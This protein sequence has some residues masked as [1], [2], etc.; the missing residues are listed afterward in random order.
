[1]MPF[2][3]CSGGVSLSADKSTA[4]L[5]EGTGA[6]VGDAVEGEGK[7]RL[8]ITRSRNNDGQAMVL[9]VTTASSLSAGDGTAWGVAP[10][11]GNLVVCES[12]TQFGG[13]GA[14]LG[15]ALRK[16]TANGGTIEIHATEDR[17]LML[18]ATATS[19]ASAWVDACVPPL[20]PSV[21]PWVL[22]MAKGDEVSLQRI[23]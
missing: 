2:A 3:E 9:G 1:M 10:S 11:R 16:G 13:W 17:R 19:Y 15:L 8:I 4:T 23:A 18:R 22:M 5:T 14:N 20:P 12:V 6:A 7:W 21:R